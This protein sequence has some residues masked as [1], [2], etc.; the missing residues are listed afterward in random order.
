[1]I[2]RDVRG[3]LIETRFLEIKETYL[4][5]LILV[6]LELGLELACSLSGLFDSF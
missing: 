4:V 2:L 6:F 3:V 1:M 5:L